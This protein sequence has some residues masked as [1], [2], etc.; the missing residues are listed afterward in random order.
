MASLLGIGSA[1]LSN[2]SV[3]IYDDTGSGTPTLSKDTGGTVRAIDIDASGNIYATGAFGASAITY[4]WDSAGTQLWTVTVSGGASGRGIAAD[5]SGNA[6]VGFDYSN[7]LVKYNSSGT[8]QWTKTALANC[9]GI[10]ISPGGRIYAVG[11]PVGSGSNVYCYNASGTALWNYRLASGTTLLGVAAVD[12]VSIYVVGTTSGGVNIWKLTRDDDLGTTS[13]AWSA[14]HGT[15]VNCCA[16]MSGGGVVVGAQINS[17]ITTRTYSSTG[18]AGWTANHGAEVAGVAVDSAGNVYTTGTVTSS[19]TTRKYNS[20]GT[21]QYSFN[22]ATTTYC[23]ATWDPSAIQTAAPGLPIPL[24]VK[25][26]SMGPSVTAAGIPIHLSLAAFTATVS[27]P[28]DLAVL[29]GYSRQVYRLYLA[30]EDL[31]ELP[32]A[33]IVCRRRLGASTWLTALVPTAEATVRAQCIAHIGG[34][35]SVYSGVSD[36]SGEHLGEFLRAVLT[37][38]DTVREGVTGT[39]T[40]TGRVQNPAYTAATRSLLGVESRGLDGPKRTALCAVDPLLKPNDTVDDGVETWLAGTVEYRIT[41]TMSHM[42]VTED[43]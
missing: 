20:S 37:E 30:T 22:V 25:L 28:P 10:S 1:R 16:V 12:D 7:S 36:A 11:T 26:P 21:L 29:T 40:L 32:L 6:Y 33:E 18:T 8:V 43:G 31:I 17:S 23:I 39:I 35:I 41:P 13:V 15:S 5:G 27:L 38:V 4:A 2:L 9:Y 3:R 24:A 14:A 34:E 42:T 19:L